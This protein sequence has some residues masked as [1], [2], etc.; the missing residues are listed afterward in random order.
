[1]MDDLE[2][3]KCS[4]EHAEELAQIAVRAYRDYYLYLWNDDS[5]WYVNGSFSIAQFQKELRDPNAAFFLLKE[6][7]IDIGFMKLNLDQPLTGFESLPALEL[8]RIYLLK[9]A[10]R[11]GFGTAALKFC[12]QLATEL[13]RKIVWL[14]SMDSSDALHFYEN[15]GFEECGT[16][17]LDFEIMK[18]EFRGM[19]V[20]MK[21][22]N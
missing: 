9:S 1:M 19:K 17:R 3:V 22:L 18:P 13:A 12:F 5:S 8:E 6:N 21:K 7:D 20:L 4:Q 2:I 10:S 15:L 11:K 14:K 16:Y